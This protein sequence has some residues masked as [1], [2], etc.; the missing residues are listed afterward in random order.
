MALTLGGVDEDR[1]REVELA[2]ERLQT[3]FGEPARVG[4]DCQAVPGQ[5]LVRE[6]V[7]EDVAIGRLR[8]TLFAGAL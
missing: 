2:G 8:A 6:D 5:R 3:L 1:L 7:R 4:E